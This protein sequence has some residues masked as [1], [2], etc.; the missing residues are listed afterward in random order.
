MPIDLIVTFV[1]AVANV[2]NVVGN[3]LAGGGIFAMLGILGPINTLK[4]LNFQLMLSELQGLDAA[5]RSK[6]DAAFV[7]ALNMSN[8]VMQAK[9]T[10]A[11]GYLETAVSLVGEG[12]SVVNQGQ[13][14]IAKLKTLFTT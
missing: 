7:G 8:K 5:S 9:I 1:V 4:A 12:I 2:L 14:L 10:A 6:I 13:A 11:E 3:V